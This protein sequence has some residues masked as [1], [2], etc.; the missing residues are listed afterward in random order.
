[1]GD[2]IKGLEPKL[3]GKVWQT[4]LFKPLAFLLFVEAITTLAY[5]AVKVYALLVIGEPIQNPKTLFCALFCLVS[6]AVWLSNLHAQQPPS[7]CSLQEPLLGGPNKES[8]RQEHFQKKTA[9]RMEFLMVGLGHCILCLLRQWMSLRSVLQYNPLSV[10]SVKARQ[11]F[12]QWLANQTNLQMKDFNAT[13]FDSAAIEYDKKQSVTLGLEFCA[14]FGIGAALWFE[15]ADRLS[16]SRAAM[17]VVAVVGIFSVLMPHL[18]NYASLVL[19]KEHPFQGCAKEYDRYV[20]FVTH[21]VVGSACAMGLNISAFGVLFTLAPSMMRGLWL[22]MIDPEVNQE[23]ASTEH[24][25][26]PT[27]CFS[28]R[29]EEHVDRHECMHTHNCMHVQPLNAGHYRVPIS[30]GYLHQSFRESKKG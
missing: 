21:A 9:L 6:F 15:I 1:M 24:S 27:L 4:W 11:S 26:L 5:H 10:S 7:S 14:V 20:G 13:L 12:H 29:R 2:F 22:I 16:W 28:M 18:P 23:R 19:D 17:G 30:E 25:P 3:I 8:T